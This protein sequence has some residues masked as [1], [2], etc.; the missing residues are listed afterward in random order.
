MTHPATEL[1]LGGQRSGKSRWA[2]QRLIDWRDAAPHHAVVLVAT[3]QAH[4]EEMRARIA[5]H[6]Q[7]RA[8]R[9]AELRLIE[10]HGDLLGELRTLSHPDTL[11]VIDC[12]TLWVTQQLMPLSGVP[13]RQDQVMS[14][15]EQ[16][17]QAVTQLPGPVVMV[18]NETGLGIVPLGTEVRNW[19]DTV[20]FMNQRLA[21]ACTRVTFMVAGLPMVLKA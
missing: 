9:L 16:L 20:G 8:E 14:T 18:S 10:S 6:Q 2:E 17:A 12:L 11:V 5:R 21:R 19:V 4:D 15:I 13:R 3:A 7:D 1:V